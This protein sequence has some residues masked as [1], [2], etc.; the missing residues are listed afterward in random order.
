MWPGGRRHEHVATRNLHLVL[1][2]DGDRLAG[3]SSF[4]IAVLRHDAPDPRGPAR[5]GDHHLL[6]P[7]YGA[8]SHG[9]SESTK[10]GMRPADI[11]DRKAERQLRCGAV[12]FNRFQ[13]PHQGG[14]L[15]PGRMRRACSD[16][17]AETGRNGDIPDGDKA[18]PGCSS[19][20]IVL[21]VLEHGSVVIYQIDLVY[22][23]H[24][25]AVSKQRFDVGVA[26]G[27]LY[28]AMALF[29][30]LDREVSGG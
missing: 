28:H 12:D 7:G 10:V 25:M 9:P 19:Q 16:I 15:I 14:T 23:K 21:D 22:C 29:H 24:D 30:Q 4:Q 20:V 26:P 2:Q 3:R 11:L 6:A 1:Q 8:R 17:V 27:L 5:F 13:M 18:G